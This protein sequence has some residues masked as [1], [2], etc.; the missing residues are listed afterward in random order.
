MKQWKYLFAFLILLFGTWILSVPAQAI[1]KEEI[2]Q[3]ST[4]EIAVT[5]ISLDSDYI[6]ID[7]TLRKSL[8]ATV[9]PSNATDKTITWT[10]SDTSVATVDQ[11]IITAKA[12]GKTTITAESSNG[13][14][15]TCCV[16]VE[17]D[18]LK[19]WFVWYNEMKGIALND[20]RLWKR[21]EVECAYGENYDY[22]KRKKLI[23]NKTIMS[24]TM[25]VYATAYS[26][27]KL[28]SGE[29][30]KLPKSLQ[31]WIEYA[32]NDIEMNSIYAYSCYLNACRAYINNDHVNL[33]I[34]LEKM[35]EYLEKAYVSIEHAYNTWIIGEQPTCTKTGIKTRKCSI[36]GQIETQTIAKTA[37][38]YDGGVIK[39]NATCEE[40]GIKIYTCM[41]CKSEK[42]ESIPEIGHRSIKD[43]RVEPTSIHNGLTEGAHCA[44]CGK[45]LIAQNVIPATTGQGSNEGEDTKPGDDGRPFEKK[46]V[47]Q[48]RPQKIVAS[49]QIVVYKN[50]PFFLKAK[51]SGGGKLTYKSSNKKVAVISAKGKVTVK[52]YGES[53]ITIKAA[54]KG[55][56]KEATKQITVK[57][58]PKA[59]KLSYARKIKIRP[60]KTVSGYE[61]YF[62]TKKNFKKNV[63]RGMFKKDAHRVR[64]VGLKRNIN[65]YVKARAYKNVGKKTYYSAWSKV[66]RLKR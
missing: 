18:D 38:T 22:T 11:G 46:N 15:A 50:K 26:K 29:L 39:K 1:E 6:V 65:Y 45:I 35:K 19:K 58:V 17:D 13:I 8:M 63:K 66:I 55:D 52:G 48:T 42:A 7:I 3:R 24:N 5:G 27:G 10:S 30:D 64:M 31:G 54:A 61:I 36:C 43:Q 60:D 16:R 32:Q 51:A 4:S 41:V 57:V 44:I 23:E 20:F 34:Y 25:I 12:V 62:S 28:E 9:E 59:P 14:G 21:G 37:H 47:N 2:E 40:K 33:S 56:Y 49:S 53:K